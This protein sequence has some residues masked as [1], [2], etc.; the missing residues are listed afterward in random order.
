M[1]HETATITFLTNNVTLKIAIITLT[2]LIIIIHII[3]MPLQYL[4][5]RLTKTR[6]L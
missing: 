2:T 1:T 6:T 3:Q 4:G 5:Q